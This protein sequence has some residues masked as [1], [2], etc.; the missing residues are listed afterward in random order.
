M[1]SRLKNYARPRYFSR[2]QESEVDFLPPCFVIFGFQIFLQ[3]ICYGYITQESNI[4]SKQNTKKT[5]GVVEGQ[6]RRMDLLPD[7]GTLFEQQR[8]ILIRRKGEAAI[9]ANFNYP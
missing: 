2:F 7:D 6:E 5:R 4:K 3:S 1:I 9:L 8:Y